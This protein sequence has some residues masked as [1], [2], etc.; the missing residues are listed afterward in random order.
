MKSAKRWALAL[1]SLFPVACHH[2]TT[3]PMLWNQGSSAAFDAM[4]GI[5]V[6]VLGCAVIAILN[7]LAGDNR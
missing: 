3:S 4:V 7:A 5:W 6:L 1:L 2:S